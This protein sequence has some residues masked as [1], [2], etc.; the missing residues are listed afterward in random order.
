MLTDIIV[1]LFQDNGNPIRD[2]EKFKTLPHKIS[3]QSTTCDMD[4]SRYT[5]AH[6]LFPING[7]ASQIHITHKYIN[8]IDQINVKLNAMDFNV[9]NKPFKRSVDNDTY[10]FDIGNPGTY[11]NLLNVDSCIIVV[12]FSQECPHD[13][14]SPITLNCDVTEL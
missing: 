9:I 13:Q 2:D 4:H 3:T 14:T 7:F 6:I 12:S 8:Y 5:S 10:T 1:Q 11:Y